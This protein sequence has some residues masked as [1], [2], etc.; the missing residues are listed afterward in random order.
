ML[1]DGKHL[2]EEGILDVAREMC[3]ATRTAPKTKGQDYI[4]TL[5]LTGEEKN[6]LADKTDEIGL[7]DYGEQSSFWFGSDAN[8]IRQSQAVVLIGCRKA[9]RG[10]LQCGWCGFENCKTC[11]DAGGNCAYLYVDLGVAAASASMVA[12]QSRVD[13]RMMWSAGKPALPHYTVMRQGS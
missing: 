5:V 7:R 8:A 6:T 13:N 3:I 4:V 12:G 11:I 1:A 9:Y 2:E 10:V